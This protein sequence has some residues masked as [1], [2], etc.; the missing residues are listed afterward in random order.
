MIEGYDARDLALPDGQDDLIA[1]LAA[2][3]PRTVVV[4]ETGG[5]VKTPW[6]G[7]AA[8]LLEAWYPGAAGGRSIAD[9]L[10]GAVNP[11]GR[12]PISFPRREEDLPRPALP[13]ADAK[14]GEPIIVDYVEGADVGYRW[15]AKKGLT[16]LFPFGYGLS[17]TRF[18]Y[19]GL[20]VLGGRR[21]R[22]RFKVV[23]TGSRGGKDAPQV[24]A[25]PPGGGLRLIGFRKIALQ[26][27]EARMVEIEADPRLL[28]AFDPA[29]GGWRLAAGGY[30]VAVGASSADLAL[31]GEA[32]LSALRLSP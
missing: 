23:N 12:L 21:L 9:I 13:G 11:S 16:P 26:P 30:R 29:A 4:L 14:K 27:G 8:A 10:F 20:K 7:G 31:R 5:P 19:S 15:Y 2:A 24:Y 22:V 3:N 25:A 17:Y 6:L 32:V 1:A 18:A 28:A